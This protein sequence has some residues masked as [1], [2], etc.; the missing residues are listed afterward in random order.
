MLDTCTHNFSRASTLYW[1]RERETAMCFQ[2]DSSTFTSSNF[3]SITQIIHDKKLIS[4]P[5]TFVQHSRVKI[6]EI[7]H[8]R[9]LKFWVP[10]SGNLRRISHQLMHSCS[11]AGVRSTM[12]DNREQKKKLNCYLVFIFKIVKQIASSTEKPS[13]LCKWCS[14]TSKQTILLRT[15]LTKQI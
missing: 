3:S 2:A 14:F 9:L 12:N 5:R 10:R 4:V 11:S 15:R 7:K 1:V 8:P 6:K 13:L